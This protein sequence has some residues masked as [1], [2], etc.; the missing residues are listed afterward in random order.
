MTEPTI[1]YDSIR[2]RVMEG[3]LDKEVIRVLER[4]KWK[5]RELYEMAMIQLL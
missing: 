5:D 2:K 4:R 1:I 3:Q